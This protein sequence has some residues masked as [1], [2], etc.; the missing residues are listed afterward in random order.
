MGK[1][2][3]FNGKPFKLVDSFKKKSRLVKAKQEL[4]KKGKTV[5]TI[6][7]KGKLVPHKWMLYVEGE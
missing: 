1:T 7:L 5:R 3:L 2:R 6:K 4:M